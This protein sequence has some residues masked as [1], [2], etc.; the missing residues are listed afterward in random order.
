MITITPTVHNTKRNSR[1]TQGICFLLGVLLS[2]TSCSSNPDKAAFAELQPFLSDS[3]NTVFFQDV[4]TT[5]LAYNTT[6]DKLFKPR[7]ADSIGAM[8]YWDRSATCRIVVT[9]NC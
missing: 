2:I 3:V 1:Q 6:V 5:A 4:R 7:V 8:M 9:E